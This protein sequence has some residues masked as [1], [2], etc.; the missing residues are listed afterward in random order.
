MSNH[1]V[2]FSGKFGDILWS[3]PTA[4]AI[5]KLVN[6]KVDFAMMPTYE[7]LVPLLRAQSWTDKVGI[8]PDWH[9]LHS[10]HGD[11]P[12]NPPVKYEEGYTKCW[13]LGYRGHPGIN[14]EA[15]PLPMFIAYQQGVKLPEVVE[16]FIE[17]PNTMVPSVCLED[18]FNIAQTMFGE[19]P[20]IAFAFNEQ[21][22]DLKMRFLR[23][24]KELL[25]EEVK[26]VDISKL[27]WLEA[28]YV[29]KNS[30][31][32]VGCR[33]ANYVLAHGVGAQVVC[34]EPHPARGQF[35]SLGHIFSS[36]FGQELGWHHSI[37]PEK[38]AILAA[39]F[40]KT[41]KKENENATVKA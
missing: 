24:L 17:V 11:Q 14:A 41:K 5:S 30:L 39:D 13:H 7:S 28:A 4:R 23:Q 32:F 15:M 2:T 34:Y 33:S 37:P 8:F 38:Q 36:P 1:L 12:W 26:F 3:L 6:E 25:G 16:P 9:C 27:P 21:Y 20:C 35:G 31:C 10:N 19:K 29:I 22:A 40:I 18:A